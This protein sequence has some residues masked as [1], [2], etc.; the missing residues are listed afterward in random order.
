MTGAEM[1][2]QMFEGKDNTMTV[3]EALRTRRSV[4]GY[5]DQQVPE[6]T[7]REIFEVAQTT[8]SNCNIQPWIPHVVSGAALERLGQRMVEA[9]K[10]GVP[11][12]PDFFAARKFTGT[13]RDRQIDA[14]VQLYGAMGIDRNDRPRRDWAYRRN[15]EFF[16]APHAV[17]IFMHSDF[18][19]REAVDLGMYA[20]S[21]MLAMTARGIASCA[22]GALG[23]YCGITREELGLDDSH[24]LIFGISFG[25]EDTTYHANQ[26]RVGR[27]TLGESVVFHD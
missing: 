27:A 25:Y 7:M 23:L 6:A 13:Y 19:A 5:T 11:P 20:Q 18:E 14:A 16:G 26:A 8:P 22:Q 9:A 2:T 21:L 17:F 4:R 24:R 10:Q 15:L 12:D 3:D 1:E